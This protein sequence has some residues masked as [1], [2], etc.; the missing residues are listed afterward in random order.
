MTHSII[1][2]VGEI[3]SY[4]SVVRRF[5]NETNGA[6]VFIFIFAGKREDF[7]KMEKSELEYFKLE[8]LKQIFVEMNV[9]NLALSEASKENIKIFRNFVIV[10]ELLSLDRENTLL[11]ISPVA[12]IAL[13]YTE[14]KAVKEYIEGTLASKY[15]GL[16]DFVKKYKAEKP[17]EA[18]EMRKTELN[19]KLTER[20][21]LTQQLLE[22]KSKKLELLKEAAEM[23]VEGQT[24]LLLENSLEK[25][26]YMETKAQ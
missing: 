5:L 19:Q 10:K 25:A 3:T 22:L 1:T 17:F 13:T 2:I 15:Q 12:P 21:E 14:K 11:G 8:I 24:N 4:K 20:R 6:F 7:A 9:G 26:K 18:A 16:V 23:R